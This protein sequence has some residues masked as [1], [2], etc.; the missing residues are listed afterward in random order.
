MQPPVQ[1]HERIVLFDGEL[2]LPTDFL[3]HAQD[4]NWPA[5]FQ[6]KWDSLE[7]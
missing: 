3:S 6:T 1:F 5:G 7:T 2:D 4:H